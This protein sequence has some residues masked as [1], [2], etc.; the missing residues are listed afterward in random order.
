[1][2]YNTTHIFRVRVFIAMMQFLDLATNLYTT[3]NSDSRLVA[4]SAGVLFVYTL[5]LRIKC[6]TKMLINNNKFKSTA[7][8]IHIDETIFIFKR[9][10]VFGLFAIKSCHYQYISKIFKLSSEF[11]CQ[12][13]GDNPACY[14][15]KPIFTLNPQQSPYRLIISINFYCRDIELTPQNVKFEVKRI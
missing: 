7:I 12:I 13:I 15:H 1:M 4:P 9:M 5:R 3:I 8:I 14:S 6:S 2:I 10:G 11:G